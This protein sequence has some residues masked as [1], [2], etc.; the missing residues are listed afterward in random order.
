[1]YLYKYTASYIDTIKI[2]DRELN[3]VFPQFVY[4]RVIQKRTRAIASRTSS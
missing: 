2:N 3:F 4:R 1:M